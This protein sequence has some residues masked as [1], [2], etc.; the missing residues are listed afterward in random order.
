MKKKDQELAIHLLENAVFFIN[1][2][3]NN[4][5]NCKDYDCSYDLAKEIDEYLSKFKK[6]D[7]R[8]SD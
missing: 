3:P 7:N 6:N 5:Y 8:E 2:V 1:H 4:K